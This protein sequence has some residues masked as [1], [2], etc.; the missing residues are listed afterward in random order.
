MGNVNVTHA[1]KKSNGF[2][3]VK[4][5]INDQEVDNSSDFVRIRTKVKIYPELMMGTHSSMV[6]ENEYYYTKDFLESQQNIDDFLNAIYAFE[7][8][9]RQF[10]DKT[11][12]E[13]FDIDTEN[14]IFKLKVNATEPKYNS[15]KEDPDWCIDA[16]PC[17]PILKD[18]CCSA[19]SIVKPLPTREEVYVSLNPSRQSMFSPT[20]SDLPLAISTTES[21]PAPVKLVSTAGPSPVTLVSAPAPAPITF[22]S[23]PAP[24]TTV[25]V[26]VQSISNAPVAWM[27]TIITNKP[28][29]K[30][31]KLIWIPFVVITVLIVILI[32]LIAF[33]KNI[34]K[35]KK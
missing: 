6:N 19:K 12:E 25:S 7:H 10:P 8:L 28:I 4:V 14:N 20:E 16:D 27:P 15:A 1:T 33:R 31:S 22:V 18:V 17:L 30:E 21:M 34:F 9:R 24:P 29:K 13:I 11:V 26:P 2:Y 3:N 5:K 35:Q 23:A 32:L